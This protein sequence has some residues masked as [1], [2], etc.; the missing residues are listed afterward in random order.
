MAV[1]HVAWQHGMLRQRLKKPLGKECPG[2]RRLSLGAATGSTRRKTTVWRW[3]VCLQRSRMAEWKLGKDSDAGEVGRGA[4][5][6][7]LGLF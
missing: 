4:C 7:P 6:S 2:H 3:E 5:P 1:G